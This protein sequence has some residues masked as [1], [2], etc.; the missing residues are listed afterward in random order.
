MWYKLKRIMMR[1]NGVEKQVYPKNFSTQ[2][3]CP[4]GFHVPL[5]SE[6]EAINNAGISLW[7]WNSSNWN[8]TKTYL[9]LPFSWARSRSTSNP[10]AWWTSWW[11][12][13]SNASSNTQQAYCFLNSSTEANA[14]WWQWKSVGRCIRAMRNN[15]IAPDSTWTVLKQ[16]TWTAGIYHNSSL[17]LISLSSDWTTRYTIAD[18]NLWATTVYNDWNTLSE[19]NCGKFY[20][21]WN[22]YWFPYSWSVTTS[23]SQVN[24]GSYWP[25]NYYSSSTFILRSSS[26]EWWDSSNNANLRWWVDGNAPA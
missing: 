21:R 26:P 10:D 19:A 14:S 13:T 7:A 17:W 15:S 11:Y 3:P 6:W 22:N 9:K 2:W 12:W 8:W 24:A 16:W 5:K 20:Q 1:P 4:D 18:K 25:W 23:S